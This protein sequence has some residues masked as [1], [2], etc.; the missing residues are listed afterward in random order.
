MMIENPSDKTL[1]EISE[2]IRN[3]C[4]KNWVWS[5][6]IM[7]AI[8][9]RGITPDATERPPLTGAAAVEPD[10]AP[11]VA[12]PSRDCALGFL[13][14]DCRIDPCWDCPTLPMNRRHAESEGYTVRSGRVTWSTP[15]ST[16]LYPE[17]QR[18]QISG[19]V[20]S[21][22]ATAVIEF[23]V[24]P[25]TDFPELELDPGFYWSVVFR[26]DMQL[27][28]DGPYPTFHIADAAARYWIKL[29]TDKHIARAKEFIDQRNYL[30]MKKMISGQ[31]ADTEEDSQEREKPSEEGTWSILRQGKFT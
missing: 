14:R 24:R 23:H 28:F 15:S 27:P 29:E 16:G 30:M 8:I 10:P 19:I 9:R 22:S 21:I 6:D 31:T 26:G 7:V 4:C 12:P 1:S 11:T 3:Y 25:D 18:N 20:K 5:N 13:L 2:E 17:F